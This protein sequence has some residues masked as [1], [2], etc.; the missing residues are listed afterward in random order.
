[1]NLI[2]LEAKIMS[3]SDVIWHEIAKVQEESRYELHLNGDEVSKKI[4]KL[5]GKLHSKLYDLKLLNFLEVADT[6]LEEVSSDI[7]KLTN[8]LHLALYRNKLTQIPEQIN[9]LEKLKFFDVSFNRLTSIPL[10][11]S[12]VQLQTL[13]LSNNELAEV[14]DVGAL[15]M[16]A[17]LHIEHNKLTEF[18]TGMEHLANL[19]ELHTSNNEITS[20]PSE[21]KELQGLRIFDISFNSLKDVPLE[22]SSCRKLKT[23]DL[24][25]NPLKDNRLKKMTSQ[26]SPKAI[27][28]YIAKHGA[29]QGGGG[30]KKKGKGKKEVVEEEAVESNKRRIV[31]VQNKGDER[32]IVSYESVKEVRPYICCLLIKKLDLSD[33]A[34]F[35]KFLTIQTKLHENECDMRT[36]ATIATHSADKLLLPLRYEA[37]ATA[38]LNIVALGKTKKSSAVSLIDN[39]KRERDEL[40]LKKKRQPKTGLYK[41]I[42]LVDGKEE[43]ACLKNADQT[44]ISLPP[45]TNSEITKIKSEVMDVFIEI[46]SPLSVSDCKYVMESLI[47]QMFAA[48]FQSRDDDDAEF[49]GLIIEPLRVVDE[50]GDLRCLFP[51]KVDLQLNDVQRVDKLNAL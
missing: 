19:S 38:H 44:V 6:C 12:L 7:G 30:G 15:K 31:I 51:S 25:S 47:K 9:E 26:C 39:L 36:R 24:T 28:D 40:K 35:K 45:I 32:R 22:L 13:N 27:L 21:I 8:I 29:K 5:N 49:N 17:I 10:K 23:L 42:E 20:I 46:T 34:T 41:F 11:F 18:P 37:M 16:L 14:V 4:N 48:G 3:E 2:F 1:M 43:L 50:S 33:A